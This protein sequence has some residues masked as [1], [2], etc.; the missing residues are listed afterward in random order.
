[1]A[2]IKIDASSYECANTVNDATRGLSPITPPVL[3]DLRTGRDYVFSP[4]VDITALEAMQCSVL[5]FSAMR[6]FAAGQTVD[7]MAYVDK[8]GLRH[9]FKDEQQPAA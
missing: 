6:A 7:W 2:E 9:H 4:S 8:H 1:M 5:L 3:L